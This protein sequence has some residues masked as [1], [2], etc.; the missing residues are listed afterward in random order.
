MSAGTNSAILGMR[1]S[2]PPADSS[3]NTGVGNASTLAAATAAPPRMMDFM[4]NSLLDTREPQLGDEGHDEADEAQGLGEGRCQN[5]DGE[6]TPLDLGLTRHSARRAES[7]QADGQASADNTET[8][9]DNSHDSSFVARLPLTEA[10]G[11]LPYVPGAPL[12][13]PR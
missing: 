8:V 1:I 13:T 11:Y 9:T 6:S 2:A 10:A 3:A 7:G 12:G 4:D 5:E